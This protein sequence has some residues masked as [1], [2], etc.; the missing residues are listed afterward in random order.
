MDSRNKIF[1]QAM[2]CLGIFALV[3]GSTVIDND[4][5]SDFRESTAEKISKNYTLSEIKEIGENAIETVIETP[6]VVSS[7]ILEANQIGQYGKP[8]DEAS[9]DEIKPVHSVS[10]GRVLKSGISKDLGMYVTIEHQNRVSTYGN[11]CNITVVS[12]D[13]VK[14][15]DIIGSYDSTKEEEFYYD[16]EQISGT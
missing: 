1:V 11:L 16:I 6:A 3:K 5:I 13:R 14:K 12:G 15:G 2:V 10:G 4:K 9:E 8:I 7:A